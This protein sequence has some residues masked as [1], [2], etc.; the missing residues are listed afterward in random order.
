VTGCS[1]QAVS[2]IHTGKPSDS[3]EQNLTHDVTVD[4]GSSTQGDKPV[5]E[6]QPEVTTESAS[7]TEADLARSSWE[8]PFRPRLWSCEGWTIDKNSMICESE[9]P[10]S[11]T[12]LRPYRNVVVECRLSRTAESGGDSSTEPPLSFE[13]RLIDK[14]TSN[15]AGLL[16]TADSVSLS[17]FIS[18]RKT[19]L[20]TLRETTRDHTDDPEVAVR[21]TMTPNRILVAINGHLKINAAR[22]ASIMH[23]DCLTQFVIHESGITLSDLR[24]E[25]D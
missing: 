7:L 20:K 2:N 17:E 10:A 12:F 21:F 22:P 11:A 23:I 4:T 8:N 1:E 13:L 6:G 16:T 24:F 14:S 19:A 9:F 25:G 18:G 5:K 15:W 3:A